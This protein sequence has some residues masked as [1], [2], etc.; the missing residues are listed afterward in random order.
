[1]K[2]YPFAPNEIPCYRLSLVQ[3]VRRA[4]AALITRL[5]HWRT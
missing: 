5:T 3:R 2:R 4:V 1:M